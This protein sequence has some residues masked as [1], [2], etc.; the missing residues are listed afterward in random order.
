MIGEYRLDLVN[1]RELNM[2]VGKIINCVLTVSVLVA[3]LCGCAKKED[4]PQEQSDTNN[5][6]NYQDQRIDSSEIS[7]KSTLDPYLEY[8]KVLL[9][10]RQGNIDEA[11]AMFVAVDWNSR[12][13]ASSSSVN[14]LVMSV[15]DPDQRDNTS[16]AGQTIPKEDFVK[17]WIRAHA[18]F[19]R[20]VRLR[21]RQCITEERYSEAEKLGE[22]LVRCGESLS[23]EDYV[24]HLIRGTGVST[25]QRAV[26]E[27]MK[28]YTKTSREQD[29]KQAE[30]R[31]SDIKERR[32]EI[33]SLDK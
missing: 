19:V 18:D 17:R 24:P 3:L 31:L 16:F 13:S 21:I 20:V 2:N 11:I 30:K 7:E 15:I 14:Q 29:I 1:R 10:W 32:R 5:K 6:S 22:N 28:L 27:L 26:E 33:D 25:Q 23:A 12:A 4:R 9:T 8:S